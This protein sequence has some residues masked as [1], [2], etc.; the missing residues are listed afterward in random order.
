[1][2]LSGIEPNA[3][4]M[5]LLHAAVDEY[6]RRLDDRRRRA[7]EL[8]RAERRIG[9]WRLV[10]FGT[11]TLIAAGAFIGAMVSPAWLTVPALAFAALVLAHARVIPARQRADRAVRYYERG[12]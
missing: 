4:A 7:A 2:S 8:A 5:S 12:L 3:P 11:G 1:M 9:T 6:P 10:V